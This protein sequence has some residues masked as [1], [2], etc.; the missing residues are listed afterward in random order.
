[1][2]VLSPRILAE[3]NFHLM[4]P[5]KVVQLLQI[6]TEHDLASELQ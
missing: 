5:K 1:M 4:V 6:I 2:D 3:S